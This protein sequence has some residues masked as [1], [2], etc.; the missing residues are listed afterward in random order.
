MDNHTPQACAVRHPETRRLILE[1]TKQHPAPQRDLFAT[2]PLPES[3]TVAS[4]VI[5]ATEAPAP[6]ASIPASVQVTANSDKEELVTMV[7]KTLA[8][9]RTAY[10]HSPAALTQLDFLDRVVCSMCL[11]PASEVMRFTH[12]DRFHPRTNHHSAHT[13]TAVA[14]YGRKGG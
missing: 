5:T 7:L 12:S 8:D 14:E 3:S 4:P 2:S 9:I 6:V 11:T 1:W 13:A 10:H